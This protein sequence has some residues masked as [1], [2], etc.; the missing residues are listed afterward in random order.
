MISLNQP[1]TSGLDHLSIPHIYPSYLSLRLGLGLGSIS[2][3][4]HGQQEK[5]EHL[6]AARILI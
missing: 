2:L 6:V 5:G 4:E 1:L 3:E